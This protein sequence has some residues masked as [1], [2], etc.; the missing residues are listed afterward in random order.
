MVRTFII[1]S[2]NDNAL[3]KPLAFEVTDKKL[4]STATVKVRSRKK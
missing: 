2:R 4:W 3:K 1:V